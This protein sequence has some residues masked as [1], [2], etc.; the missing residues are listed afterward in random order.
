MNRGRPI[1]IA[2][3]R[4]LLRLRSAFPLL[5]LA[6]GCGREPASTSVVPVVEPIIP[7]QAGVF[8]GYA[9][10]ASCRDCHA[11]EYAE[12]ATSNHGLAERSFAAELDRAAFDP[13]STVVAGT[14]TTRVDYAEGAGRFDAPALQGRALHVAER[15]IGHDPLRQFLVSAPGGRWQ[16]TELAWD[17]HKRDWFSVYGNEDRRPGEW[18]HWTGRGMTW[19][20]MCAACHNTRLR[21]NYE[22]DTDIFRTA[23]AEATAP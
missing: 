16:S 7:H 18:G 11:A 17:P 4:C 19:N 13:A 9:G 20:T 15:V 23:M 8:E 2:G 6:A 5:L 12:W 22:P 3:G 14:Q 1:F 10:S 21:K